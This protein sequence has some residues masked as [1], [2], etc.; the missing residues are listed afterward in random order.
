MQ[1]AGIVYLYALPSGGKSKG[2]VVHFI[3]DCLMPLGCAILEKFLQAELSD[4]NRF[5]HL[6]VEHKETTPGYP[7]LVENGFFGSIK[8]SLIEMF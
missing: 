4:Y 7:E 5:W 2:V 3:C 1:C 8:R 6:A